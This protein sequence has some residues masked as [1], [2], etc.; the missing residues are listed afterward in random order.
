MEKRIQRDRESDE[1]L[2][3]LEKAYDKQRTEIL[4]EKMENINT[5]PIL[6]EAN[7]NNLY[8]RNTTRK[9]GQ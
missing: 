6:T 2:I 4:L 5:N 7:Y 3:D 8:E 1:V 9:N